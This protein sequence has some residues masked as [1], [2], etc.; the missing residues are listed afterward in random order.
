MPLNDVVDMNQLKSDYGQSWIDLGT[1]SGKLYG[2]FVWSS[3]KGLIWYDPKQYKGP[4]PPKTWDEL[5]TWSKT[6]ADSGK[7]TKFMNR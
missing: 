4:N 1:T 5:M 3:L 2:I 7:T 6:T